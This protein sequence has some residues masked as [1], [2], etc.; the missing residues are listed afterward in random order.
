MLSEISQRERQIQFNL[1]YM[2]NL[3]KKEKTNKPLSHRSDYWLPEAGSMGWEK[4]VMGIKRS[5]LPVIKEV[6]HGD[7]MYSM[8][9][10]VTTVLH[11]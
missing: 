6:S 1:T 8:V 11:I 9:T 7:I 10:I 2:W 5:K 3:K 4:W